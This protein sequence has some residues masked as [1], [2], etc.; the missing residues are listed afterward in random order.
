MEDKYVITGKYDVLDATKVHI[1]ELPLGTWT[2]DYKEYLEKCI[3]GTVKGSK[4]SSGSTIIKSY[5]DMSTDKTVDITVTFTKGVLQGLVS[6]E[7]Q[8]NKNGLEK[9]LKLY[10]THSRNNMYLFDA[11]EKLVKFD[12]AEDIMDAFIP[13]RMNMYVKRKE[14]QINQLKK[15]LSVLSNK[16]KFIQY[17]LD[18]KI[19]LRRKSN[20]EVNTILEQHEF[21]MKD[22]NYNYLRKMPMDAVTK[23]KA[24]QLLKERDDKS[25]ELKNLE[26]TTEKQIWIDE[27]SELI[28]NYDIYVNKRNEINNEETIVKKNIKK[29]KNLKVKN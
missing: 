28:S 21:E 3:D 22:G 8:Y 18:D 14:E 16:A 24:V 13:T 26:G 5:M 2:D 9:L 11:N 23:E 12:T 27:L 19:D 1:T 17:N 10:T 15:E 20:D 7:T 6:E 29:S 4:S 25:H